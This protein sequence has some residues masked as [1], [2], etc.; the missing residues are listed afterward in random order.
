MTASP[1][2]IS[3][4][5]KL[6]LI[7]DHWNPRIVA[8][9]NGNDVRLVK[10]AGEFVW[11]KH[12]DTDEMFLVIEGRLRME[13]RDRTEILGPGEIIVVPRGVEHR[14]CTDTPEVSM[15]LLDREGTVNTGDQEANEYTRTELERI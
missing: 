2:K 9:Y 10:I 8:G 5:D 11:H 3:I 4:A 6:G 1:A 13:F 15:L 14:P 12:D 7:G